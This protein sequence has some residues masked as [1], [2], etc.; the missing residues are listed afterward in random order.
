MGVPV[1][2]S[3]VIVAAFAGSAC[4]RESPAADSGPTDAVLP[5]S[6]PLPIT[7]GRPPATMVTVL[8]SSAP[9][10][11]AGRL[12]A[13]T[14]MVPPDPNAAPVVSVAPFEVVEPCPQSDPS[15]DGGQGVL[16][17]SSRLE[18]MLGQVLAYGGQ[19]PDQFGSYGLV[20]DGE[21]ASV[22][23]SFTSDL[24]AHRVALQGTVDHP[25]ELIV[26]QVA[27]SGVVAQAVQAT[28]TAELAGR[29]VS[30]GRGMGPLEVT[31]APTEA[32]LAGEL[33]A[34]YGDAIE[35]TVGALLY[36][37]EDAVIGVCG[38]AG[39]RK[40]PGFAHRDRRPREL[41]ECHGCNA[42]GGHR[43]AHQ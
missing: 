22:F 42:S 33:V 37:I 12:P 40:S 30:I 9:V 2:A 34:R 11:S 7:V 15:S 39:R 36:P 13:T 35:V 26:C 25:D 4:G 31:L 29:F 38:R 41:V 17:E 21:D 1:V 6:V 14:V 10:Q 18:S 27:M 20:W 43:R 24:D 16:A 23:V 32:Q 19:R 28:L 8:A 5:S 3:I